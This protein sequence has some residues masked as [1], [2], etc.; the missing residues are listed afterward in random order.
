[1]RGKHRGPLFTSLSDRNQGGRMSRSALRQIMKKYFNL[2]GVVGNKTTHSL[3]HTA[4]TKAIK[5]VPLTRVSKHLA[6]HATIDTTMIY[7]HEADRM[8]D[9]VED[10][11]SYSV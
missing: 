10:H 11:I 7:V 4:I 8:N 3:R 9:P 1:V 6:R 5:S 2:A